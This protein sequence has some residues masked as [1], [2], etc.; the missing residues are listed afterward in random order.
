MSQDQQSTHPHKKGFI[1][2][3]IKNMHLYSQASSSMVQTGKHGYAMYRR[4]RKRHI[5]KE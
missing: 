5:L 3:K 2:A 4:V 1:V